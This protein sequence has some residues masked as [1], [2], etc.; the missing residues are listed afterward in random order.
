M[1]KYLYGALAMAAI[2]A[3]AT[4][5]P[6]FSADSGSVTLSIT[7]Q[8]PPAPCLTVTPGSVDFG[9]LPFSTVVNAGPGPSNGNADIAFNNCGT[10]SQNLLGSA[11]DASSPSG[12]WSLVDPGN[13]VSSP[14]PSTNTFWLNV[15]GFVFAARFLTSTAAP[16]LGSDGTPWRFPAGA[17]QPSRL[18]ITMPCQ[19][20]NGAGATKTLT[21]TFTAVV[22]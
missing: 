11:T 18:T 7:A 3:A 1:R 21:A 6:A 10:A 14:C 12:S 19:G 22:P 15:F 8:A 16:V 13:F 17:T 20:S 4:A 5:V 9:T 2:A